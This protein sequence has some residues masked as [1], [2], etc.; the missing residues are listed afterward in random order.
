[1]ADETIKIYERDLKT[2]TTRTKP[3]EANHTHLPRKTD[4][5]HP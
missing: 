4:Q 1:M 2:L 5:K 3:T